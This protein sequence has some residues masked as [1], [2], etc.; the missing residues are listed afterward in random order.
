M[1]YSFLP[2]SMNY[3]VHPDRDSRVVAQRDRP[4][5]YKSMSD[6][7]LHAIRHGEAQSANERTFARNELHR[8]MSLATTTDER[9]AR[10]AAMLRPS[11]SPILYLP[12]SIQ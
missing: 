8:R 6:E 10:I 7:D 5:D 11:E 4:H 2:H 3:Q 1:F 12:S 9:R